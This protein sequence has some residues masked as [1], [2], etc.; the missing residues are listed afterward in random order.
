M[1]TDRTDEKL[2][3]SFIT[4][5]DEEAMRA[6][7]EKYCDPL[8]YFI[9]GIVH[10]IDDA[11]EIMMD[12]FA[13]V[14][15]ATARFSGRGGCS[16]KTWLYA[17]ANK[18][19]CMFLRKNHMTGSID[20][21]SE[22]AADETAHPETALLEDEKNRELYNALSRLPADQQTVLYLKYFEDMR[23]EEISRVMRK[24]IR[25]V[26]KLTDRGKGKLREL[27]DKE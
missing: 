2:Y 9:N 10:N 26:Y 15:S 4:R 5:N 3:D 14:I 16:F 12:C 7:F 1:G 11:Q 21:T 24:S 22:E 23:P 20:A 25:Q 13:A 27:L 17:V 6:L 8:T 18:R 19:S